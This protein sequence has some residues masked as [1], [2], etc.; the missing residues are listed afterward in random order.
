MKAYLY[1][2]V[3]TMFCQTT[4]TA[5][6]INTEASVVNFKAK[7]MGL[8]MVKGTFKGMQGTVNFDVDNLDDAHFSVTIATAT[9]DTDNDKRDAHLQKDDFFGVEKYPTISFVSSK[10][11]KT[12]AGYITK[13]KLTMLGVSKE[14]ELPFTYQDSTL[15]GRMVLKRKDYGLASNYGSFMV[16]NKIKLTIKC[17]LQ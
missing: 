12:E 16:G 13:G 2:L 7:N 1:L 9:V 8:N 4:L 6:Q 11:Y 10:I 15:E 14:I 3:I 5:Q 17:V